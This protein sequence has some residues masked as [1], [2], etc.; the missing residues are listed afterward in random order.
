M[1][2]CVL[3]FFMCGCDVKWG[4]ICPPGVCS[5]TAV[6]S[7]SV[8]QMNDEVFNRSQQLKQ[9][10][11]T[12]DKPWPIRLLHESK[13][14][15]VE[16]ASVPWNWQVRQEQAPPVNEVQV[17]AMFPEHLQ[18]LTLFGSKEIVTLNPSVVSCELSLPKKTS[19]QKKQK[20]NT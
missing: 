9:Q 7:L 1:R 8:K 2:K 15:V 10:P 12:S 4:D 5:S 17:K 18:P 14:L 6:A 20:K 16:S 19:L 13:R 11:R 3:C